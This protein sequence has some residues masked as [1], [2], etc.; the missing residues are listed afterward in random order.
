MIED[1]NLVKSDKCLRFFLTATAAITGMKCFFSKINVIAK[2]NLI[3]FYLGSSPLLSPLLQFPL[4]AHSLLLPLFFLVNHPSNF[5]TRFSPDLF[6]VSMLSISP[7]F[8]FLI[9]LPFNLLLLALLFIQLL[10][11]QPK[12]TIWPVMLNWEDMGRMQNC[13]VISYLQITFLK[14]ME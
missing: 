7:L 6:L 10:R 11:H 14:I 8:F 5:V 13:K 4:L 1:K 9:P 12:E 2:K 3:K